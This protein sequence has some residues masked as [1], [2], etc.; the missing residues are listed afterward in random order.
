VLSRLDHLGNSDSSTKYVEYHYFSAG[1]VFKVTH[2]A[3]TYGLTLDY[4]VD[5]DH[6]Y[7]GL[8]QFGR[9][10]EQGIGSDRR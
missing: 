5:G 6:T 7:A 10:I 2:P 4:D 8:D 1:T 9:I 3:L